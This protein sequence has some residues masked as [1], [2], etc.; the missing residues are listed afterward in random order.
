[1]RALNL[2]L[3]L[4]F[5]LALGLGLHALLARVAKAVAWSAKPLASGE[6]EAFR[7]ER[8]V[9]HTAQPEVLQVIV[10]ALAGGLLMWVGLQWSLGVGWLLGLL[11]VFGA[12]VMDLLRWARVSAGAN[13]LWSQHGLRGE[14]AQTA[15]ENIT[16]VS[17]EE[18]DDAGGFTLRRGR[19]N[20]LCRLKVA[21]ANGSA[22]ELP[23]TDGH[24]G[25]DD[26]EALANHLRA[27]Q[28]INADAQA[29]RNAERR[30]TEAARAAAM[31]PPSRDAE[32][33]EALNR[34]RKGALAP[35]LPKAGSKK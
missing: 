12:V 14:V 4:P 1:M 32:E 27:R 18:D 17:V 26:V 25:F 31:Q 24:A 11:A 2:L 23:W 19:N 30:A 3:T 10:L 16:D 21:L 20:R 13:F 22:P 8:R 9:H 6:A 28:Q 34:L 29:L 5:M 33:L 7:Y 15:I 35:D